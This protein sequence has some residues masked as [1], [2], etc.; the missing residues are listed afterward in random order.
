MNE[1]ELVVTVLR[2]K[3]EAPWFVLG[4]SI[5]DRAR[6]CTISVD[7]T[8]GAKFEKGGGPGPHPVVDTKVKCY[9]YLKCGPYQYILKVN[10]ACVQP[11]DGPAYQAEPPFA[12]SL[13]AL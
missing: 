10:A 11:A 7:F 1:A 12:R 4:K 5:D 13:A 8:S 9:E 2:T 3:L 6:T